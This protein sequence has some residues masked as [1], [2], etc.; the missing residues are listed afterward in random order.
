[1]GVG[2][3]RQGMREKKK[4]RVS[5]WVIVLDYTGGKLRNWIKLSKVYKFDWQLIRYL[6]KQNIIFI[7]LCIC[8][9]TYISVGLYRRTL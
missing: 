8:C 5:R 1:M 3:E 4:K 9:F 2:E 6:K 7:I